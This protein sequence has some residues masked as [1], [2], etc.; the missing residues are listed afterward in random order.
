M[1]PP[2][3]AERVIRFGCGALFGGFIAGLA[4]L[5]IGCLPWP[6]WLVTA[7]VIMLACGFGAM[8]RGDRF[9]SQ[10]I[11]SLWPWW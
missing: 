8:T 11:D 2:D 4:L 6:W 5:E 10:V 3:R 1:E 7:G 9:W